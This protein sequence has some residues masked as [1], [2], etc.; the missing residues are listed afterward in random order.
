MKA[1]VAET[2]PTVADPAKLVGR[3]VKDYGLGV[4]FEAYLEAVDECPAD[5]RSW[6]P[7]AM[8]R[9]KPAPAA[10]AKSAQ[11]DRFELAKIERQAKIEVAETGVNIYEMAGMKAVAA[12]VREM[13]D[14][15]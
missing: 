5:P 10:P 7:K 13:I 15:R 9:L 2:C 8:Q 6:M 14:A 3:W 1:W 12:K 11:P 4:V